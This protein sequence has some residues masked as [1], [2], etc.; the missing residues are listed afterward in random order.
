MEVK[1][2]ASSIQADKI[3]KLG[4]GY[5]R[6]PYKNGVLDKEQVE[7]MADRFLESGGTYFDTAYVYDG[8]E[9]ALRETVIKRHPRE[10]FFVASK[11]PLGM[12][13]AG[14][15][16][17]YFLKTSLERLGTD[18]IDFYLLHGI[19]SGSNKLAEKYGA[20]DYL[21]NLKAQGII[22]HLGFSFH[23]PPEDLNEILSKHPEAEFAQLQ[24]NYWDWD[25]PK[26]QA[27]R[28]YEI[29]RKFDVPVIIMEPLLGGKLASEDSPIAGL[30]RGEN[31]NV[32][33]ASWGLRFIKKLDGVLTML[34][35]MST[36]EQLDDNIKT[37]ADLKP[38]SES[39][40]V[41]INKAVDI[42]RGVPRIQ[43]TSC[44]YCKDCPAN[45]RIP[46][47]I[48]LYNNYT[49]HKTTAN[50]DGH[51]NWLTANSGKAR[52]CTACGACEAICPQ[53]LEIIDTIAKVSKM[54]D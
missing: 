32:S 51:Y 9:V 2:M 20:W 47:I 43:C 14:R 25:N 16:L 18:Y 17:E 54:F 19:D 48:E 15:S 38:L 26:V 39:E 21:T 10:S 30:L 8:A 41:V 35:G 12:V 4:F 5:M 50:L 46:M 22:R 45:I 13:N 1:L 23:G 31:P 44:N 52:D 3:G 33:V 37:Y 49:I 36:Y 29:A 7:K 42:L 27:R 24:I 6:L 28:L 40:L 11:L 53:K 34:S